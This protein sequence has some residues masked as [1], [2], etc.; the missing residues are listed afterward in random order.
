MKCFRK[1]A[2][3]VFAVAVGT[4]PAVASAQMNGVDVSSHN[5]QANADCSV[6]PGDF[7]IVKATEG[8]G[9]AFPNMDSCVRQA[10]AAGKRVGVY[11]Y[12][13]PASGDT[14]QAE[15]AW[16]LAHVGQWKGRVWCFLDFEDG[17]YPTW[18]GEWLRVVAQRMNQSP[19]IY[20]SAS[21]VNATDWGDCKEYPL[22][23]AGYWH[24]YQRFNGYA[25]YAF[26]YKVNG[27]SVVS[28]FQYTS[29]GYLNGVGAYDLDVFYGGANAWDRLANAAPVQA[30]QPR[31]VVYTDEQLADQVIA[32][33][34][35]VG[36]DRVKALG[37]RYDAVQAIVNA[38]LVPKVRTHVVRRGECLYSVFGSDWRRVAG[39]NGI[40]YP[41][42][43][44]PGQVLRY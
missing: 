36:A 26:P 6:I 5:A 41:Y 30:V 25:P 28:M 19:G 22:W 9:Y 4:V 16:F 31:P 37:G 43:I 2:A 33:R 7:I 13:R 11:H 40:A 35:G 3:L 14:A 20:M 32:G 12:A 34:Y 18:A 15:A 23:V 17:V 44:Y 38:R 39:L 29:S 27:W 24:G 10:L 1:F 21:Y 8:V 42:V